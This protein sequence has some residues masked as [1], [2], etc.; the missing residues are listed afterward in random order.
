[1]AKIWYN[2]RR[3]CLSPTKMT[4]FDSKILFGSYSYAV[5]NE[6][7]RYDEEQFT[8]NSQSLQWIWF[9]TY[10]AP[11][12]NQSNP[13]RN[14]APNPQQHVCQWY[15][16]LKRRMS[17]FALTHDILQQF[18]SCLSRRNIIRACDQK[19]LVSALKERFLSECR[20]GHKTLHHL[21]K[22]LL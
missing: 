9:A 20:N 8:L 11:F 14:S 17:L 15:I 16:Y 1:M 4:I 13:P 5:V 19:K 21:A 6:Y 7:L 22:Y 2:G 3:R 10:Q 18:P 12:L